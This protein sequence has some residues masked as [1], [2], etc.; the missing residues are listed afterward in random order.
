MDDAQFESLMREN[1]PMIRSLI[2]HITRNSNDVED[3]AQEVFFKAYRS[4]GAFRGG[5]FR[6][7]LGRIARNHCYDVL[8]HKRTT[9]GVAFLEG[10]PDELPSVEKGPEDTVI[11]REMV[12]EVRQILDELQPSDREILL[13]RHVHQFSCEE[14]ALVLGIKPGAVRTRLSR[15]RQRVL[16]VVERRNGHAALDLG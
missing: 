15:A 9:E 5:S 1:E 3:I 2:Y 4:L 16:E 6:A 7:Y 10:V 12:G 11:E 13:L 14:I 8:R